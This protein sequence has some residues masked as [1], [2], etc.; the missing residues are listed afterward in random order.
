[1]TTASTIDTPFPVAKLTAW[2][3]S[4][5][6]LNSWARS[7]ARLPLKGNPLSYVLYAAGTTAF[8]YGLHRFEQSRMAKMEVEM[9]RLTKRRM[10]AGA[11]DE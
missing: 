3:A 2:A 7:M 11:S 5:V 8:G 4:G 1:M 9:D 6:F 10:M